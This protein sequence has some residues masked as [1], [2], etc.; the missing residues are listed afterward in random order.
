MYRVGI[1][2]KCSNCQNDFVICSSCYRGNIYCSGACRTKRQ[3]EKQAEASRKYAQSVK[4]RKNHKARQRRYRL[5]F[6]T[7]KT[8]R[9]KNET[10]E[11]SDGSRY[12]L[13]V[14]QTK[15]SVCV[16]CQ[17]LVEYVFRSYDEYTLATCRW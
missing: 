13:K 9:E 15:R 10:H 11:T 8:I 6:R 16:I 2:R 3:K 4:G 5:R 12:R 14:F 1:K 7:K 17:T